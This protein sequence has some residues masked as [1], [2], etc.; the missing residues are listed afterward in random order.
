MKRKNQD[1]LSENYQKLRAGQ[2]DEDDEEEFLVKKLK[3]DINEDKDLLQ[4]FNPLRV[5][6]R[7]LKKIKEGGYFEGKNITYFG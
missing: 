3:T 2:N 6:K 5:S 4:G 7:G 1:V